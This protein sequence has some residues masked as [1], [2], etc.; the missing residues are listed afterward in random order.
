MTHVRGSKERYEYQLV[1]LGCLVF[2]VTQHHSHN[3]F[4]VI[5]IVVVPIV[6]VIAVVAIVVVAIVVV[7]IVVGCC[8]CRVVIVVVVVETMKG[9][10]R[11]VLATLTQKTTFKHHGKNQ[12]LTVKDLH[13][14]A[15]YIRV[16]TGGP[17]WGPYST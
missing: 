8:C 6:V 12:Q 14:C 4:P 10:R 2:V 16:T 9:A 3:I 17:H 15:V 13:S 7:A 5:P 1:P 11:M